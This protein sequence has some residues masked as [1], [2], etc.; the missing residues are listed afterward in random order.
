M[1]KSCQSMSIVES[2]RTSINKKKHQGVRTT[3]NS[4]NLRNDQNHH[5][6][7]LIAVE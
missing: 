7:V 1:E 3:Q 4:R 5:K 2:T 6:Q